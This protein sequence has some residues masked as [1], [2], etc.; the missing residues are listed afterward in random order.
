MFRGTIAWIAALTACLV[1]TM[2]AMAQPAKKPVNT[3]DDLPRH[4]YKIEGKASEFLLTDKPFKDLV[5]LVK[6]DAEADL[7]GYDIKDATTLQG[8]AGLLMQIAVLQGRYDD[9]LSQVETIRA[10]EQKESKRLMT[11]Q[12]LG[13]MIAARKAAASDQAKF[14]PEFKAELKKRVSALSWDVV[15][16]E[17][18]AAKGR[19]EMFS[20][21]LILGGLEGQLDPIVEAAKGELSSELARG[22]IQARFVLDVML[23][24]NPMI[25]EVYTGII[26]GHKSA[27]VNIWP[28]R[29]VALTEADKA[30]PVVVSVWDSGVDTD[31]FPKQLWTNPKET[32]NGKDDDSN[33]FVDDVHGIAYDLDSKPVVELLC[34]LDGLRSERSLVT[35]HTKGLGDLQSNVDSP[36]HT[37]LLAFLKSLKREDV[38]AFREDLGLFGNFSHGTHVAGIASDGNP[39]I[40]LLPVRIT[41]DYHAIPQNTPTVARAEADAK[42]VRDTVAYMKKAGV[43]VV[44]MSWGG[45]RKDIEG[46][47]EAKNWGKSPEERA[48]MSRRLFKIQKDALEEAFKSAPETLFIA[49][50]GNADSD[51]QFTEFIP[52]GLSVPN[53][54]TVGAVDQ[55]GKPT[56]FTSFG[57]NVHLYANG[58]EVESYIPGGQ[59]LKFNGT[60]MA[61]PQVVNLAAKILAVNP[62]LSA[63]EVIETITKGGDPMPG[64]KD[65]ARRMLINPKKS[66]EMA[67]SAK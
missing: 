41:F 4:I 43:R 52:S 19:A 30:T 66:V 51:N 3:N 5:N 63:A 14:E 7:A 2:P 15:R 37:A 13:S 58:F 64:S 18:T 26:D 20:R 42:A 53:M 29:T 24:L 33:G 50:A 16:E 11:G 47:L 28:G 27:A 31:L 57:G 61:S 22:L 32:I 6:A 10:L 12:G 49:A 54:I 36:E 45:S 62:K 1:Q 35:S 38:T 46:E 56:G 21:D 44:N 40:R 59:R 34:P 65:D 55:S 8:Y 67:R 9:A 23:P 17:V 25:A 48:D 60:S 39:Y